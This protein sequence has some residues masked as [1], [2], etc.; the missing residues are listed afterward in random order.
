MGVEMGVEAQ[1]LNNKQ[2]TT[3]LP[4]KNSHRLAQF[5]QSDHD[6]LLHICHVPLTRNVI[7]NTS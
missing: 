7:K 1:K 4:K 6:V 3:T 2:L 5:M